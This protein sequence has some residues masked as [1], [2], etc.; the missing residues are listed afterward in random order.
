[1]GAALTGVAQWV[2]CRTVNQ[3]VTGLIPSQGAC[4]GCMGQVP[5]WGVKEATDRCFS[6]SLSPSLLF[7]LK[8]NR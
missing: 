1:M 3:K 8:V 7:S 4:L 5:S 6:P 2:G